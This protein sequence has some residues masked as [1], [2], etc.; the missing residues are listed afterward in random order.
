MLPLRFRKRDGTWSRALNAVLDTGSTRCL[1]TAA[2][3]RGLGIEAPPDSEE[4]KGAGGPFRAA[5]SRCDARIVDA[6]YPDATFWEVADLEVWVPVD[7]NALEVTVLGWD[8]LRL[9]DISVSHRKGRID[10]RS[11]LPAPAAG[12][13]LE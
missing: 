5:P 7:E 12:R 9:F 11:T 8:L 3:A 1:L 4:L 10:L 13:A 2:L 6:H